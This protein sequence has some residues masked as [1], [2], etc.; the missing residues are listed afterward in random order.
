MSLLEAADELRWAF[1]THEILM[2]VT[3][4]DTMMGDDV[5]S[6]YAHVRLLVATDELRWPFT[7]HD[8]VMSVTY[9]ATMTRDDV[10]SPYAHVSLLEAADELWGACGHLPNRPQHAR[11][12]CEQEDP[13]IG[14]AKLVR[15]MRHLQ[16]SW[17]QPF[18]PLQAEHTDPYL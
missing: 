8:I 7:R 15:H 13:R 6:P 5:P 4:C 2:F 3:N 10:S 12:P 17:N 14:A 16:P 1:T 11:C 9:V 18:W